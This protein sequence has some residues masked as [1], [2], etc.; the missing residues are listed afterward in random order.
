MAEKT[1][2]YIDMK[3]KAKEFINP[4]GLSYLKS[5]RKLLDTP[6]ETIVDNEAK[7]RNRRN[8]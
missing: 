6:V 2:S 1:H 7:I 8:R 4:T 5:S 3:T